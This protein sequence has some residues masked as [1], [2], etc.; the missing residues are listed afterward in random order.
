MSNN[1]VPQDEVIQHNFKFLTSI[2]VKDIIKNRIASYAEIKA[3][4]E[5]IEKTFEQT[6][7]KIKTL[8]DENG[9]AK[10]GYGL[11]SKPK[12]QMSFGDNL[13]NFKSD[14]SSLAELLGYEAPEYDY[15]KKYP[16]TLEMWQK[17]LEIDQPTFKE[18]VEKFAGAYGMYSFLVRNKKFEEVNKFVIDTIPMYS[19]K[20]LLQGLLNLSFKNKNQDLLAIPK[21]DAVYTQLDTIKTEDFIIKYKVEHDEVD[22]SEGQTLVTLKFLNKELLANVNKALGEGALADDGGGEDAFAEIDD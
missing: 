22:F 15:R 17:A 20:M 10:K 11:D 7:E 19:L 18:M 4:A 5:Q 13:S 21:H 14:T 8:N 12:L 16:T 9:V 1:T 6:C 2:E 3:V